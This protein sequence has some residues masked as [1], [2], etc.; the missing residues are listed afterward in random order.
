MRKL[1]LIV[2]C[3]VLV[4]T[5]QAQ[6]QYGHLNLGE[7]IAA[8][9]EAV[10]ANDSLETMQAAMVQEGEKLAEEWRQDAIQFSK[11]AQEGTLTPVQQQEQEAALTQR[12]QEIA[13][14]EQVI[15]QAVAAKRNEMLGPILEKAQQAIEEVAKEKG[16][17]MVFDTSSFGAIHHAAE[18]VDLMADVK[19]K[20][21]L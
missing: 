17:L 7:L 4:Y 1:I 20:L 6:E 5:T 19:A 11:A 10:A 12:Q 9:P 8:M 14:L 15:V 3:L 18:S 13:Q 16:Y 2:S 21:G